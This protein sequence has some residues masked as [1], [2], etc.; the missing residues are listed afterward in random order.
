MMKAIPYLVK[1]KNYA[2]SHGLRFWTWKD[3][4]NA[5]NL[6]NEHAKTN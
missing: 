2:A 5:I 4:I 1:V 6:Y 3:I